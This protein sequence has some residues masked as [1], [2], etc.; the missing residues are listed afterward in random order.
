MFSNIY[1]NILKHI[2][3]HL[4]TAGIYIYISR[5]A[6][7]ITNV[8]SNSMLSVYLFI[9]IASVIPTFVLAAQEKNIY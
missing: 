4:L 7:N 5:P 2:Y 8:S 6:D 3:I 1:N 9:S